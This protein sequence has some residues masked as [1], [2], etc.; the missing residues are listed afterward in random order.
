MTQMTDE[1]PATSLRDQRPSP[2]SLAATLAGLFPALLVADPWRPHRALK[3][4]IHADLVATGVPHVPPSRRRW[5]SALR[6]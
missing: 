3:V 5:R 6:P 4:G 2:A 1:A